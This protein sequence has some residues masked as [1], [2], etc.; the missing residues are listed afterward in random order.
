[1]MK[2]E[3]VAKGFADE[4]VENKEQL[5][6]MI[7]QLKREKN[8][9]ILGHYYQR[10]EIQDIADFVGDSLAMAQWAAKVEADVLV[11]CGVHFMGETAKI[12]CP[13]KMVLVPDLNAGCSLAD[14]CPADKFAEFVAAHPEHQV[15]SYVNTSAAVK[16][17]T[18]VVVTSSNAQQ[19]VE[20]FPQDAKL[21]FGPDRNLGGYINSI[22]GRNMLLWDGACHVHSQFSVGSLIDMKK[23]YPDA[24]VLA[25]PECKEVILKL[26]DVIGSTAALLSYAKKSEKQQF[27]V[28]TESGIL[29]EMQKSCP[30]KV[31]IPALP[32]AIDGKTACSCN[33]CNYMRLNTLEKV[34]NCLRYEYPQIEVDAEIAAKAI[35]PIERMLQLSD[36]LVK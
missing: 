1:M 26:A 22:T 3:W 19:I 12:L 2:S 17:H 18:D 30:D 33:E 34:Y 35:K 21:I 32:E 28:V 15:I 5:V 11:V 31:F 13:D 20:S 24:A 8:A 6:E 9:V 7:L 4:P 14:S 16:A 27:I 36:K 10:S 25:H 29:H 23:Q